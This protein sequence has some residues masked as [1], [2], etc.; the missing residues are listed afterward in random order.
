MQRLELLPGM[1]VLDLTSGTGELAT[2]CAGRMVPLGRVIAC[3][4]SLAMLAL[5]SRKLGRHPT[6]GWHVAYAQGRAEALPFAEGQFHA[7]TMGFALRNVSDLDAAFRE[8]ARVVRPGGRIS[9]LEFGRPR[10]PLLKIGHFLWLSTAIPLLGLLITGKL[11]PFLYLRRSILR[12]IPPEGVVA[13]LRSAGF[14]Q[15]QMEPLMG[16]AVLIYRATRP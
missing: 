11:W 5:A 8:L 1:T 14:S 13:R 16:E 10:Q 6:V 15:I 4:L 9:L 3:D 2:E 12:F 7:A